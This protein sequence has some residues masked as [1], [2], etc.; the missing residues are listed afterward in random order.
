METFIVN[1]LHPEMQLMA[2]KF[3]I[4]FGEDTI[5]TENEIILSQQV[6]DTKL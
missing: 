6:T 4:I 3:E 5:D 2:S 1:S